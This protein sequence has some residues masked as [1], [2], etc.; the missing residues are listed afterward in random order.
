MATEYKTIYAE[1]P[2]GILP[3]ITNNESN[4]SGW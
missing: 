3:F 4:V 1:K 2:S